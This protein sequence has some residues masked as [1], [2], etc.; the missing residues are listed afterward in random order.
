M[1][2]FD[3]L[4]IDK[5]T[6]ARRQLLDN[7]YA[8]YRTKIGLFEAVDALSDQDFIGHLYR[9]LLFR[10]PSLDERRQFWSDITNGL[11]RS[12]AVTRLLRSS[13]FRLSL[14]TARGLSSDERVAR[15]YRDVLGRSVDP[16]GLLAYGNLSRK[17]LGGYRVTRR[18]RRSAEGRAA[19]GGRLA[20]AANYRRY[21][22]HYTGQ[23]LWARI[24]ARLRGWHLLK[25]A[26]ALPV[27]PPWTRQI[28]LASRPDDVMGHAFGVSDYTDQDILFRFA[29]RRAVE[30]KIG[31]VWE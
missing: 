9:V 12:Q 26:N 23:R 7:L 28:E 29:F 27:A 5:M 1:I 19:G 22:L 16:L 15:G 24:S 30:D 17:F 25:R 21:A 10:G 3:W 6:Y 18:L 11:H 2:G 31:V 8:A 14:P 4:A 20:I 13:E